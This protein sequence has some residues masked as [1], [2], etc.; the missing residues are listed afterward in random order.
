VAC[1]SAAPGNSAAAAAAAAAEYAR[2][3]CHSSAAPGKKG[4]PRSGRNK[5]LHEREGP[6]NLFVNTPPTYIYIY[7]YSRDFCL[8]VCCQKNIKI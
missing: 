1:W 6:D 5:F 2:G 4:V 3:W 8:L 7:T